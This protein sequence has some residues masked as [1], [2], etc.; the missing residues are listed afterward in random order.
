MIS[1]LKRRLSISDDLQDELLEDLLSDA[2]DHFKAITGAF[3]IP[4]SLEF[5]IV[6]VAEK[7]YVRKGSAGLNTESVDGYSVSYKDG[8]SD[9][10]EYMGLLDRDYNLSK[11]HREKGWVMHY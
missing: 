7:R 11:S 9:F 1:K 3:S 4:Q 8:K 2:S 10:D 6:D 5:I